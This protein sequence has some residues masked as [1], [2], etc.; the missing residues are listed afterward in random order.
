VASPPAL[1]ITIG[2]WLGVSWRPVLGLDMWIGHP[3]KRS[4]S[5][6]LYGKK[7]PTNAAG[8]DGFQVL[9]S[10]PFSDSWCSVA[11]GRRA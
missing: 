1:V 10:D 5:L 4:R 11:N 3:C 6:T 9:P 2:V 8:A 7:R